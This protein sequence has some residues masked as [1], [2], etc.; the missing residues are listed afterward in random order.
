MSNNKLKKY[1]V[2]VKHKV[3]PT[4]IQKY[5]R[6]HR[7]IANVFNT[8]FSRNALLAYVTTPFTDGISASHQNQWSVY[9]LT[10]ILMKM[11]YNVDVVEFNTKRTRYIKR[12]DMV[13]DISP[14]KAPVYEGALTEN[15]I[16]IAYLTGSNPSWSN[17]MEQERVNAVNERKKSKIVARRQA[18][19]IANEIEKYT[20]VLFIGNDYNLKSYSEF[21]LPPVYFIPN[22]GL[23]HKIARDKFNSKSFCYIASTGQVHKGLDLLLEV[24]SIYCTDCELFIFSDFKKEVDFCEAYWRELTAYKNIHAIG[25]MDTRS[26]KFSSLVKKCTY[27]ILPSCSEA[28]CGSVCTAMGFGLIP[29]VSRE[30]GF[31]D[32]EVEILSDCS[33]TTIRDAVIFYSRKDQQWLKT[34]SDRAYQLISS[35]YNH[36][37]QTMQTKNAITEIISNFKENLKE[38]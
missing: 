14:K 13:I 5:F 36:E 15:C 29:I 6:E 23:M 28:H 38:K 37:I 3:I 27:M 17:K 11:G 1:Y 18:D 4:K 8:N 30:C 25:F 24:F 33:I 10:Q 34:R 9:T 16:K 21:K 2:K 7:I 12:Y 22:Y 19:L 26:S 31:E 32:D 35:K 20:A